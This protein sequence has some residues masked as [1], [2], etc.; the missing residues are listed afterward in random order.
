MNVSVKVDSE[1]GRILS[2]LNWRRGR[3]GTTKRAPLTIEL[4]WSKAKPVSLQ[5]ERL[6]CWEF[7]GVGGEIGNTAVD[8]DSD[9]V[10]KVPQTSDK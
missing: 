7:L 9:E 6:I 3:A 2:A 8:A 4:G 10:T 5:V 1:V